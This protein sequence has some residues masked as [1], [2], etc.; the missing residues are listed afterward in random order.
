MHIGFLVVAVT[1]VV[2][3]Q[4]AAAAGVE[5]SWIPRP[6]NYFLERRTHNHFIFLKTINCTTA[7]RAMMSIT[8]M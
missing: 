4:H 8:P 2:T 3:T 6:G 5:V 7:M 1:L